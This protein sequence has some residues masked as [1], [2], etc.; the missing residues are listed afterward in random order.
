MRGNTDANEVLVMQRA[1][2]AIPKTAPAEG[3]IGGLDPMLRSPFLSSRRWAAAGLLA[4]SWAAAASIA[5]AAAE[6]LRLVMVEE[7]GC[8]FCAKWDADVGRDYAASDEGRRAP[9]QRVARDAP[10]LTGL[11]PAVYTPTFILLRGPA[12]VGRITGYPGAR[13]FWEELRDLLQK[14]ETAEDTAPRKGSP[15]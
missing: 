12:E 5:G 9:L 15:S 3:T 1:W 6:D 7:A 14:S 4:V 8:R 13:Y 11:K 10:A 2:H